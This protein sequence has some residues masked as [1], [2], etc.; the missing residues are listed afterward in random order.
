[1]HH[2]CKKAIAVKKIILKRSDLDLGN[3]IRYN[4]FTL[5]TFPEI[6]I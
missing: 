3:D 1:M 2:Y 4:M 5:I 6:F